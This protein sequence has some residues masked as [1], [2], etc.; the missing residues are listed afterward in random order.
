[1]RWEGEVM[2][3]IKLE[4]GGNRCAIWHENSMPDAHF[5]ILHREGNRSSSRMRSRLPNAQPT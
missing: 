3:E 4:M 5:Q 2:T 1:M